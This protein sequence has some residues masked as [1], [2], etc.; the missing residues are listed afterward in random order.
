MP[1]DQDEPRKLKQLG[2][3][4]FGILIALSITDAIHRGASF[5]FPEESKDWM[6]GF[7]G[8]HHILRIIASVLGTLF[9]SFVAGCIA[10]FRGG[11]CGLLSALP[12]TIFWI[13]VGGFVFKF[14]PD[15]EISLANWI[16]IIVLVISSPIVGFYF[17]KIGAIVRLD[18]PGIFESRKYTILGIKWYQWLWLYF[19]IGWIGAL[20]TYSIFQ[21]LWVLFSIRFLASLY[22]VLAG[23]VGIIIFL[24]IFYL[25]M[26]MYRT[27]Y[28]LSLGHRDDI[29]SGRIAYKILG[30]TVGISCIVGFLQYLADLI[31][32]KL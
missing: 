24:S 19:V 6:L 13:F 26:G 14:L 17:G 20:A 2:G 1:Q 10:K 7:W 27:F 22:N 9:G 23:L 18:N 25:F 31:L 21:G 3:I 28:L 15:I 32:I 8:D 5:V 11:L 29:S 16:V 12:T 30:W 4:L